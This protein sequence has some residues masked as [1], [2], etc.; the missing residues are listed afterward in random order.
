MARVKKLSVIFFLTGLLT[1]CVSQI[2]MQSATIKS[3]GAT[4][5]ARLAKKEMDFRTT[6]RPYYGS[7]IDR[8]IRLNNGN[9][10]NVDGNGNFNLIPLNGHSYAYREGENNILEFEGKNLAWNFARSVYGFEFEISDTNVIYT[11]GFNLNDLDG[12]SYF[13]GVLGF[14]LFG[15]KGTRGWRMNMEL[16]WRPV[17]YVT[18][19]AIR[20]EQIFS[21]DI[22]YLVPK[23]GESAFANFSFS[24]SVNSDIRENFP[25]GIFGQFGMGWQTILNIE[26]SYSVY[27]GEGTS[28]YAL[29]Y[30]NFY[31]NL[32]LGLY[33]DLTKDTRLIGGFRYHLHR[34][35][36]ESFV[37]R[38]DFFLQLEIDFI[39]E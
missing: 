15:K 35:H 5:V 7:I 30:S 37:P 16:A 24:F 34:D 9:H 4:S 3:P 20:E 25:F 36:I 18:E 10:S 32:A 8:Q 13:G 38:K 28:E 2:N 12:K 6:F 26:D 14:G 22:I 1:S 17:L 11:A 23:Q 21:D 27:D 33:R 29:D 19:I 39:Q 31:T